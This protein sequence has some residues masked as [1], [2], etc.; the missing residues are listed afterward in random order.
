MQHL[1]RVAALALGLRSSMAIAGSVGLLS[2]VAFVAH[3]A[4]NLPAGNP[5]TERPAVSPSKVA[6]PKPA[7][8]NAD[9]A[10]PDPAPLASLKGHGGPVK[11]LA[12][13]TDGTRLLSGSFDYSFILWDVASE[14]PKA[15]H[16][17]DEVDGAINAVTFINDGQRLLAAGDAGTVVIADVASKSITTRLKGHQAKI[18]GVAVSSDGN[19]A[20]T[21]S[22]D[23]T[24]RIWIL[25][26]TPSAG[27]VLKDHAAPV[28]AAT[29]STDGRSVFTAS[30]D[31]K[32]RHFDA[33]TG[34]LIRVMHSHGWGINALKVVHDN[35]QDALVFGAIDGHVGFTDSTTGAVVDVPSELNGHEKPV[36]ALALRATA[37]LSAAPDKQI[38]SLRASSDGGGLI[39]VATDK[40]VLESFQNPY[41]PV[42]ALAFSGDG[43]SL[44]YGGLDDAIHR[45]RISPRLPFE[46]VE[47]PYPRRFQLS[48]TPDDP[49]AWGKIQFARKCSVCHT[50]E[51]DGKNRAGPTLY[52]IF[53]RRI[54]TLP[55]Y[56]YSPGL[57][58]LDIVW[59]P[60]T[61]SRLFELG[62]EHFTPGSK[63][64]L[65]K[66]RDPKARAALIA[67]LEVATT[68]TAPRD[69]KGTQRKEQ[70]TDK[71]STQAPRGAKEKT[72]GNAK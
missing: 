4:G 21:A 47:S 25:G 17:F 60:E 23:R 56:S 8:S 46:P 28:N 26:E 34:E 55:G 66:M 37:S 57:K 62:P 58:N 18:V 68:P 30:A 44:Y 65:Q 5:H 11:A 51:P 10:P 29:F 45:W 38:N 63:M 6:D 12:V 2:G 24:A 42:W 61:V 70:E 3:A 16:R 50:L 43:K 20:V 32:I 36:L 67:Y 35:G 14:P 13:S 27:P 48:G 22:W 49:V 31:G 33:G 40:A 39:I 54:A 9:P 59:S 52:G 1:P 72:G 53:G 7:A 19:R 15:I 69:E 41:G 71:P 64:P